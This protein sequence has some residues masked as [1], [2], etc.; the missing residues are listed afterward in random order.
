MRY[1]LHQPLAQARRV[2]MGG[3][4]AQLTGDAQQVAGARDQRVVG[5]GRR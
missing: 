4:A 3:A 2:A 1:L 5:G